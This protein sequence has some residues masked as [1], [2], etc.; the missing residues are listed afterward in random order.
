MTIPFHHRYPGAGRQPYRCDLPPLAQD[1]WLTIRA[2]MWPRHRS[3][4]V[5]YRVQRFGVSRNVIVT[6]WYVCMNVRTMPRSLLT[7][8]CKVGALAIHRVNTSTHNTNTCSHHQQPARMANVCS[9]DDLAPSPLTHL[10][11]R[12]FVEGGVPL[13]PGVGVG[14]ILP[15]NLLRA[16]QVDRRGDG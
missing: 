7:L 12:M 5:P 13:A 11:E 6:L 16:R 8:R 3:I 15:P 10:L 14:V 1:H 4:R 9:P 2:D